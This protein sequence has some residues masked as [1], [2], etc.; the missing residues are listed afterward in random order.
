MSIF[1][2]ALIVSPLSDGRSWVLMEDFKYHVGTKGS[3]NIVEA[4][5]LPWEIRFSTAHGGDLGTGAGGDGTYSPA[6]P[7]LRAEPDFRATKKGSGRTNLTA[8]LVERALAE[9]GGN[10]VKAAKLLGVGRATL[11]RFLDKNKP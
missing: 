1:T 3:G 5:N 2:T 9:A 4:K 10:K 8:E 6:T 7:R 11:Y